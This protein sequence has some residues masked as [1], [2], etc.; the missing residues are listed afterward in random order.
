MNAELVFFGKRLD[1]AQRYRRRVLVVLIYAVLAVLMIAQ[2]HWRIAGGYFFWIILLACRLFLGGYYS[3]GLVKLFND[4]SPMRPDVPPPLLLLKLRV[5]QPVPGANGESWR[6]DER[7]LHQR[8]RAH[9]WAYQA[10]F[11]ASL[12]P[13]A[14]SAMRFRHDL[15]DWFSYSSDAVYYSLMMVILTLFLTLPQAILLWNEPD[16]DVN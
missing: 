1:M 10:I 5:Y 3:G 8:D 13:L 16:M 12:V 15:P 2:I 7:E 14:Y 9:Y 4:K 6:N 11:L